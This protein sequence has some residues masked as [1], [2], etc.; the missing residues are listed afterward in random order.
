LSEIARLKQTSA[1]VLLPRTPHY[2]DARALLIVTLIFATLSIWMNV[3]SK[4]FLEADAITH[5]LARRFALEQPLHIVGVWSR[6]LCVLLYCI[7]SYF[8]GLTGTRLMSL[9]LVILTML[10]TLRVARN[11][12]LPRPALA[13]GFLLTSPLLFA[14]SFSELTEVP[15]ALLLITAFWAYQ[16]KRYGLLAVLT[17][18]APLGRPEGFGIIAIIAVAL[19]LHRRL[20]WLLILPLGLI[21][22][23]LAGWVVFG[24]PPYPW[25]QWLAVNWPYSSE[26][27][28]GSGSPFKLIGVLP[29]VAGPIAFG[30]IWPGVW[31]TIR[32]ACPCLVKRF[33]TDHHTRTMLLLVMIPLGVL[34][35]HSALWTFGK[36]ASNGEPR[37]LLIVAPFW[38]LLALV[39]LNSLMQFT[40]FARPWLLICVA[41]VIPMLANV[42]YPSFPIRQQDDDRLAVAVVAW[43]EAHP[44]LRQ[45]YP[46]Y[47]VALPHVFIH[48]DV[49]RLSGKQIV[50][51]SRVTVAHPPPG[52]ILIYDSVYSGSNSNELYTITPAMLAAHGWRETDRISINTRTAVIYL[53]PHS[54]EPGDTP[55]S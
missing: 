27:M 44:Q 15:F 50:D 28:Y 48:L 45:A 47:A 35:A 7:P 18:I 41:G 55:A 53:S 29:A 49:D 5:Y 46:K 31:R 51:S 26:S 1:P 11:M 33:F 12:Q 17:S 3:A 16:S 30:F 2:R 36:M 20:I 24:G 40:R 32:D 39:G 10:M 9:V 6:P 54:A 34:V 13:G 23:S 22:W 42:A 43:L 8:G 37:Y 52:V 25:W 21:A 4:D 19:I 38:A 14:H